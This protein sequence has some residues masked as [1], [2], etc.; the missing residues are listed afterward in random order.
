LVSE[1]KKTPPSLSSAK[2]LEFG[3]QRPPPSIALHLPITLAVTGSLIRCRAPR[4][5]LRQFRATC[6][7]K[8]EHPPPSTTLPRR[9]R[10]GFCRRCLSGFAP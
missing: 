9:S 2:H 4:P 7:S 8:N 1:Q 10:W 3:V 5:F 6:F